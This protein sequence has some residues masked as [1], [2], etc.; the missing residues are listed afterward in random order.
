[1]NKS[2]IM[3]LS[4]CFGFMTLPVSKKLTELTG[5][6]AERYGD[7]HSAGLVAVVVAVSFAA[8]GLM[9]RRLSK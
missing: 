5:L 1:M 7:W 4:I 6:T 9:Y 2:S 3:F 8:R